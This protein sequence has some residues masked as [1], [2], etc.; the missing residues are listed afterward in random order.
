[1]FARWNEGTL[2]SYLV[3]ISAK[4]AAASD[5]V[6]GDPLLDLIVDAAGQKGTG[7][8]TAIEAL[9]L[10]A[11][12]P[13]IEAAVMAR[14]VSSRRDE[15]AAGQALYGPAPQPVSGLTLDDLEQALIAGKI[16]CYA[17]GFAMMTAAAKEFGWALQ[18]PAIARVWRA[19]C[20]IRSAMLN[21]MATA[22]AE[23]PARN[24]ILAPF[25]ADHLRR[26]IPSLRKLVAEGA[27][28]GLGLPALSYGLA[29]FDLMR[30]ARGTANLIQGQRDFF[31]L[32]GFQ[33]LDGL[34]HPHGPW[35]AT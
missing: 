12:I 19:G 21:D 25:F 14:N 7:R 33:R 24:L 30:T 18:M 23:E 17:Q 31:G 22:L 13:V 26:T 16:L 28:N 27:L 8:W 34:T 35:A 10:A 3:E 9:H 20:I 4:V 5:P 29:W 1:V 11:P 15:R 6:T 32:H 2:K